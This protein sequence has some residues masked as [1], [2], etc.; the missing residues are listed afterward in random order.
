MQ[1]A[2]E[3]ISTAS[4]PLGDDVQVHIH[5]LLVEEKL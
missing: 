2:F 4:P 5:A 1:A 3:C